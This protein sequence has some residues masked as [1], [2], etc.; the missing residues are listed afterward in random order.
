MMEFEITRFSCWSSVSLVTRSI[1]REK[2]RVRKRAK[3]RQQAKNNSLLTQCN[4]GHR[5][6]RRRAKVSFLFWSLLFSRWSKL[7]IPPSSVT[8]QIIT[9]I[10]ITTW[11]AHQFTLF[12]IRTLK[13]IFSPCNPVKIINTQWRNHHGN[14]LGKVSSF[15]FLAKNKIR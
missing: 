3:E 14:S 13:I 4:F 12:F 6:K 1:I 11:Q 8:N 5:T 7:S 9:E 15:H 2:A 10:D